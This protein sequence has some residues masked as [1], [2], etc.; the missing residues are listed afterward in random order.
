MNLISTAKLF[1]FFFFI[2]FCFFF[3]FFVHPVYYS[4]I[5]LDSISL[6]FWFLMTT[7]HWHNSNK[8]CGIRRNRIIV[9]ASF[10]A[11][12]Q[13]VVVPGWNTS[14]FPF[15]SQNF[16]ILSGSIRQ[17]GCLHGLVCC[18]CCFM[19]KGCCHNFPYFIFFSTI[20]QNVREI[21]H[22][23]FWNPLFICSQDFSFYPLCI[24]WEI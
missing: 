13:Q 22:W 7:C 4:Y 5:S 10:R 8:S 19:V 24:I 9:A 21:L 16:C 20:W 2:H 12:P 23:G 14:A 11:L 1:F 3:F 6:E 17:C 15:T 18:W